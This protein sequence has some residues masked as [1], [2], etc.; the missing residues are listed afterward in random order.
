VRAHE[1][2]VVLVTHDADEA[3]ALGDR[4]VLVDG[5]ATIAEGRPADVLG[6]SG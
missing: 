2:V 3:L 1:L 5:G 6:R 4:L